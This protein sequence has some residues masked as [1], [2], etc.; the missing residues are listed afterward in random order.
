MGARRYHHGEAHRGPN[1]RC[2]RRSRA[3]RP[4]GRGRW[5]EV[6]GGDV[7]ELGSMRAGQQQR[8]GGGMP[9]RG[10]AFGEQP[11]QRGLILAERTLP[12]R[13]SGGDVGG[14]VI[15]G[16]PQ[17]AR[18]AEE[19]SQRCAP[20][21]HGRHRRLGHDTLCTASRTNRAEQQ[22]GLSETDS[23]MQAAA[24]PRAATDLHQS[25][26]SVDSVGTWPPSAE[27][28]R[29]PRAGCPGAGE[30][31]VAHYLGCQRFSAI[32]KE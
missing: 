8:G 14:G 5:V 4:H 7:P 26:T 25:T 13:L 6:S 27:V 28:P 23:L 11:H 20:V 21:V 29:P 3:V 12:R 24:T 32:S 19:R 10:G 16:E 15:E 2:P 18:S 30:W 17:P 9:S 22:T 31:A 1:Q